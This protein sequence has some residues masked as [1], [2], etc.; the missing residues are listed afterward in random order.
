MVADLV[1]DRDVRNWVLIPL[2]LSVFLL[3]LLRQYISIVGLTVMGGGGEG[4]P[5]AFVFLCF[6]F[7][8]SWAP[9]FTKYG[10]LRCHAVVF[11]WQVF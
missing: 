3:L 8:L 7:V 4:L 10:V 1:I 9:H 2:T 5:F 11:E 6:I